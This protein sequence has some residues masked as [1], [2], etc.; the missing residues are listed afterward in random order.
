MFGQT[1]YTPI[2]PNLCLTNGL[3]NSTDYASTNSATPLRVNNP[4]QPNEL[5]DAV[6]DQPLK[7]ETGFPYE[8]S[9]TNYVILGI[10]LEK[11]GG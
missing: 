11:V 7:F 2:R 1:N 3:P 6:M 10:I 8:Y 5:L 4:W 9:Y